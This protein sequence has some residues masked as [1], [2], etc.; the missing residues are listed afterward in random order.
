MSTNTLARPKSAVPRRRKEPTVSAPLPQPSIRF[1]DAASIPAI[2]AMQMAGTCLA[3]E[4]N[5][6]DEVVF[7]NEPP[8]VGDFAIF[9]FRPECLRPGAQHQSMI[10]RMVLA[11]PPW[12]TFPWADNPRSDVRPVVV[13]E[14]TN[15]PGRYHFPCSDLLGICRFSHVQRRAQA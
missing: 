11:I 4:L 3:P 1:P 5:H 10:K 9:I 6:G 13:A 12:V 15:P 8:K 7:V 14:Q 2:F